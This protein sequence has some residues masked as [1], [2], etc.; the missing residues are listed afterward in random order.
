MVKRVSCFC[1]VALLLIIS[2]SSSA[3]NQQLK[4][5]D[6]L[7]TDGLTLGKINSMTR[8]IH[9]VMW[10]SDQDYRG[11]VRFDGSK[12]TRFQNDPKNPNSLGGFYPECVYADSSGLIWIG[13]Y[14]MGLD[15]FDPLTGT[16]THYR[17]KSDDPNSLANDTV[18][19]VLVDH[20][21]NIW[22]GN[23]GG[24]DLLDPK[25]GTFKH[26]PNKPNDPSSLSSN[27]IRAVY[28]D[29]SGDL[30]VGSGLVWSSDWKDGGLNLFNRK[31]GTFTRYLHD[32]AKENSLINNK[33]RAIF[34]DSRGTLWIG[35]A[36]DGLHSMDKKTGVI[37]RHR[38]DPENPG[39]LSRP[40]LFNAED[41]ITFITEDAEGQ[42]WIGTL[43]A[44]LTRYDFQKNI[45]TRFENSTNNTHGYKNNSSWAAYASPDGLLWVSTQTIVNTTLYM[46][47]LFT[48]YIPAY[49]L[50]SDFVNSTYMESDS[51]VWFG[52][53]SG[54]L[55]K[56]IVNGKSIRYRHDSKNS[57][58]I[59]DN[60]V[61][62]IYKDSKDLFWLATRN[63]LTRFDPVRKLFRQYF[64]TESRGF[65]VAEN[66][67][68]NIYE[69]SQSNFWVATFGG[70]L[71]NLNPETGIY[72]NYSHNPADT[73]SI[74]EDLVVAMLEDDN[75]DLWVGTVNNG[76]LNKMIRK[77]GKFKHYL[78]GFSI[79]IM[80]RDIKGEIWVGTTSELYRYDKKGDRF[81]PLSEI[82]P[83]LPVTEIRSIV[84]DKENNL[85]IGTTAGIYMLNNKRDKIVLFGRKNN[86]VG[87]RLMFGGSYIEKD[88]KLVIENFD[89]YYSFYP[90][91]I[92]LIDR[93]LNIYFTHLW[94]DGKSI[95]PDVKG[96][97]KDP[98]SEATEVNF[99]HNQNTI[100]V[101][102]T[103]IKYGSNSERSIYYKLENY[104]TEWRLAE[105]DNRVFYYNIP[106]GDYSFKIKAVNSDNG[107][108]TEK[109]F[110]VIISPPWWKTWWAYSLYSLLFIGLI[111][112]IHRIQRERILRAERERTR[113]KE[114]AQAKEI[115][116]AY[117]I[118][119]STQSQLIQSEKMA[120][121]GELTAGIAHEIQNPLNFVN[122]FSEVSSEMIDEMNSEIEKGNLNEV[123]NISGHIKHN[124]EKIMHHG[125]RADG[126]V[127]GML[128]HSQA[129]SGQKE[130]TDINAL[131]D[132]YLRLA[133]HGLRAKDKSF[134]VTMKTE[135]DKN[136]GAVNIIPQDIG[137]VV[138]NLI[139]NAFYAVSEKDRAKQNGY[140]P[141]VTV[142]TKKINQPQSV[143]ISVKDNGNGIPS[144]VLDKIFQPFFTT[145]PAGQGTGLGLSL[146]YDI[147]KAQGGEI[148]VET[149]E[150][151]GTTF[152]ILLPVS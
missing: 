53:D 56:N 116:K 88:G 44:G 132:E 118:L 127:K 27:I 96:P 76:G 110:A 4:F 19:S 138:L 70:G 41:H 48:N 134:N 25:T 101:S 30:W 83:G 115:E 111:F 23:Y 34:E 49:V 65:G 50:G 60:S 121:L 72:T 100:S 142:S 148:K 128:Q 71:F 38:N 94:I 97:L 77:T 90:D 15:K 147:I 75:H 24:L 82:N 8:D 58:S 112:S 33:V 64:F 151:E 40:P 9:G 62:I 89:G 91:R 95:L 78:E 80:E 126:I 28:E 87:D 106:P 20:L 69:D 13:F 61:G 108:W 93:P 99:K 73:N 129:G 145:K 102:F 149:K 113:E 67:V 98:I 114:F 140:V 54:L 133:Y 105:S 37:T 131:A 36:G 136:I 29:R 12:M 42:L 150:G 31:K 11:I 74:S 137:R 141:T 47:D 139:T 7:G 52:T 21:G 1:C 123:K 39:K 17:H 152:N 104:D 124:L 66:S 81:I 119:K 16:F 6:V 10:F 120:S 103:A 43:W 79:T 135:F 22:V 51:V 18:T 130:P 92:K 122:N 63:G 117:Q 3:Q 85:W 143:I 125:K 68:A 35:T 84:A 32:S 26:Y 57:N 5:N 45:K 46:A 109:S 2:I 146:S 86:V 144:K 59:S 14:G 107:R 55:I